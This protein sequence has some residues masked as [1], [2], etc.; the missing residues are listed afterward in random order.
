[1]L[2]NSTKKCSNASSYNLLY[3]SRLLSGAILKPLNELH[4][5]AMLWQPHNAIHVS[6]LASVMEKNRNSYRNSAAFKGAQTH[7]HTH[8]HKCSRQSRAQIFLCRIFANA[9]RQHIVSIFTQYLE[10]RRICEQWICFYFHLFSKDIDHFSKIFW[11]PLKFIEF[12]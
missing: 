8:K 5:C 9:T 10:F 2:R 1:M 4:T 7:F 11:P 3:Y 12:T 6:C